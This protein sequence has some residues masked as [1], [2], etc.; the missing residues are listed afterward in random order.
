MEIDTSLGNHW[1]FDQKTYWRKSCFLKA[2]N[3]IGETT[4]CEKLVVSCEN[5][6]QQQQEK[7]EYL[8]VLQRQYFRNLG[9][10]LS[11]W[12]KIIHFSSPFLCLGIHLSYRCSDLIAILFF[13]QC[14]ISLSDYL[15]CV[16]RFAGSAWVSFANDS[17]T[18][19]IA[20]VCRTPGSCQ[21][22]QTD[23]LQQAASE[24]YSSVIKGTS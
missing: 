14:A 11:T 13:L 1:L 10:M 6:L 22:Q 3:L 16:R 23:S 12:F 7:V 5:G 19:I 8:Q 4:Q 15:E 9:E 2:Q 17:V 20:A 24:T 18:A 21:T